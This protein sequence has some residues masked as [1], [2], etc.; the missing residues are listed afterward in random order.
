MVNTKCPM[1]KLIFAINFDLKLFRATVANTNI[2][3]LSLYNIWYVF[4]PHDG[5][6]YQILSFLTEN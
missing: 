3:S 1:G 4:G 6:I 2:G 5:E